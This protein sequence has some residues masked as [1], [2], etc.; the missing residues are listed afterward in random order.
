MS[1]CNYYCSAY[2]LFTRGHLPFGNCQLSK[3]HTF[4]G[5]V[6]SGYRQKLHS[7][8]NSCVCLKLIHLISCNPQKSIQIFES[9]PRY[10]NLLLIW[11][12]YRQPEERTYFAIVSWV[13]AP[14]EAFQIVLRDLASLVLLDFIGVLCSLI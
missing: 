3:F 12:L 10:P 11:T 4:L 6:P 13:I 5:L 7:Y 2:L 1:V 14:G 8:Y 9:D